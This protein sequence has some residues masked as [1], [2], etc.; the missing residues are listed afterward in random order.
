MHQSFGATRSALAYSRRVDP[1]LQRLSIQ[2]GEVA[3]RNAAGAVLDRI[4]AAKARK[5]T[6]ETVNALE[7]IVGELLADKA[8]LTLIAQSLDDQLV[9]QR[10][11][12]DDV[13]YITEN[14]LPVIQQLTS[15]STGSGGGEEL[16]EI[17]GPLLS[18]ETLTILQL[19]GFNFKEAI[20]TPLTELVSQYIAAQGPGQRKV[21]TP[22]RRSK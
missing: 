1:E 13:A 22:S 5:K 18:K 2:L 10:L 8:E 7:E 21:N 4:T 14:L 12:E 11:T 9:A 6:E 15:D 19:I 16:K 3:A 20:G 17:V